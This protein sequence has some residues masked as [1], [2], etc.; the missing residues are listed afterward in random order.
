[1][2]KRYVADPV[3]GH[4]GSNEI[5]GRIF[6]SSFWGAIFITIAKSSNVTED[7]V[8]KTNILTLKPTCTRVT[9]D[10]LN[11]IRW[12]VGTDWTWILS[13]KSMTCLGECKFKG[14]ESPLAIAPVFVA[15]NSERDYG[16]DLGVRMIKRRTFVQRKFNKDIKGE[17]IGVW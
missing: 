14:N 17:V 5:D 9:D 2:L 12:L 3:S 6:E 1:M 10:S 8:E 15:L 11:G 4:V 7:S 16:N 13:L